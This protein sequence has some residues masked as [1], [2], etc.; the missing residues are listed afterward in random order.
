MDRLIG[1]GKYKI[2]NILSADESFEAALCMDVLVNNDYA[3]YVVNIYK[4]KELIR[5]YL[6]LYYGMDR[7]RCREFRELIVAQGRVMAVF[8]YHEGEELFAFFRKHPK[9]AY[10]EKLVYADALLSASLE[11]DL[12]DDAIAACAPAGG[13]TVDAGSR[14]VGFNYVVSPE[15]TP[16]AG[17]RMRALGE[18]MRAIF[19]PHR[20]LPAEIDDFID[21]L[22]REGGRMTTCV[23]AYAEWRARRE[24]AEKTRK[25]YLKESW[26]KYLIRRAKRKRELRRRKRRNTDA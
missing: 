23:E 19:P 26:I 2:I 1:D 5:T 21:E 22:S 20:Y 17:F 3:T 16:A 12:Q 11:L 18:M 6:P 24:D 13:V 8:E 4:S 15:V 9:D 10:E 25:Q 7:E 14:R